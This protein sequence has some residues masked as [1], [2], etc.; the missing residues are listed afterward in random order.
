[1]G[2][3]SLYPREEGTADQC[4]AGTA[5]DQRR[6][7]SA[8]LAQKRLL[9]AALVIGIGGALVAGVFLGELWIFGD[10]DFSVKAFEDLVR[11]WGPWGVGASIGLMVV[12][13]FI[14][15]PAEFVALANGMVYGSFWGTVITWT[16][17][18]LGAYLAF[19]LSRILGR[20][21]VEVMVSDKNLSR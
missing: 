20:P 6:E 2:K 19:G 16:G 10:E 5:H 1:M 14:P 12:H 13:S 18:M 8:W 15:F 4:A 11:S 17:A 3:N 21:I 7:P 9:A